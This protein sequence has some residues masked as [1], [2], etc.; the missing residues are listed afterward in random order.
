MGQDFT[1]ISINVDGLER[2]SP[3]PTACLAGN[4]LMSGGIYGRDP[5]TRELPEGA[6]AQVRQMFA[7]IEA[8]MHAA[9][10][11]VGDIVKVE[12]DVADMA[13]R[14]LVNEAW[15]AMFPDADSR[16]A[17]HVVPAIHLPEGAH[18]RC[19]IF[20]VLNRR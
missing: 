8:V 15:G 19:E 12:F 16:P 5:A 17:R 4:I 6:P 13:L 11:G 20:A 18:V 3:A 9:G 7:N 1:R 14:G 10:A 2:S